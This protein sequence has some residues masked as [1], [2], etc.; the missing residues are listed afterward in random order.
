MIF[1]VKGFFLFTETCPLP[2]IQNGKWNL[3]IEATPN[4]RIFVATYK[5]DK[6][7]FLD[8]D[9]EER[10][11]SSD[12]I[13]DSKSQYVLPDQWSGKEPKCLLT[14]KKKKSLTTFLAND[15]NFLFFSFK[16]SD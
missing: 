8:A 9:G 6:G 1:V 4:R 11:C 16:Y 14:G 10:R 5:C 7:Y 3:T 15:I 13:L 2:P 12:E